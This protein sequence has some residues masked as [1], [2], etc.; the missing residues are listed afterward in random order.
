MPEKFL[1]QIWTVALSRKITA[2]IPQWILRIF[3]GWRLVLLRGTILEHGIRVGLADHVGLHEVLG[4]DQVNVDQGAIIIIVTA[5]CH[6]E[7][8]TKYIAIP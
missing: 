5:N 2:M 8:C 6:L 7:N 3:D 4:P 1:P